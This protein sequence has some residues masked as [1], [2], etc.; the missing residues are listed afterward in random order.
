MGILR[1][2]FQ[3]PLNAAE[4]RPQLARVSRDRR[5]K[6]MEL[7]KLS[8]KREKAIDGIRKARKTGDKVEMTVAKSL[9]QDGV[10]QFSFVHA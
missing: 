1:S 3:K 10:C 9:P 2:L 6:M 7:R 4:L 8:R 5:R